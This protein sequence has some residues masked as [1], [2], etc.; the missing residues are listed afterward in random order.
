MEQFLPD[1][2]LA[3]PQRV[4]AI[5]SARI[6]TDKIAATAVAQ[7]PRADLIPAAYIPPREIRQLRKLLRAPMTVEL[8]SKLPSH[9]IT[10]D[11]G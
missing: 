4:K 7:L 1:I 10:G 3:H 11:A 6:K 5:A 9:L 8:I 2:T